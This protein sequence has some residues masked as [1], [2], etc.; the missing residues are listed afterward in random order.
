MNSKY[1]QIATDEFQI[2]FSYASIKNDTMKK[3]IF[4]QMDKKK[5]RLLL[6]N[7]EDLIAQLYQGIKWCVLICL[8]KYSL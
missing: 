2:V 7:R 8:S 5:K 4:F 6:Q 1:H 3:M